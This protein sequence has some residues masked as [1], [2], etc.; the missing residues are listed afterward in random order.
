MDLALP[1][2]D[3]VAVVRRGPRDPDEKDIVAHNATHLPFRSWRN[4][5][6]MARGKEAAHHRVSLMQYSGDPWRGDG[7]SLLDAEYR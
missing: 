6:M 1:P 7:L 4:V 2:E 3:R 5:C